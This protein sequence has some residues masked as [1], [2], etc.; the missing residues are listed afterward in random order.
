MSGTVGI[1]VIHGRE[2]VNVIAVD[3]QAL[4]RRGAGPRSGSSPGCP[5]TKDHRRPRCWRPGSSCVAP[6]K[7]GHE[8]FGVGLKGFWA[9]WPRPR[10]RCRPAA[11]IDFGH[12]HRRRLSIPGTPAGAQSPDSLPAIVAVAR[13]HFGGAARLRS[14]GILD[15]KAQARHTRASPDKVVMCV[16]S[17]QRFA[18]RR[19]S[20][21]LQTN[22]NTAS[23]AL[24]TA[25]STTP[26][27][28]RPD[29]RHWGARRPN[30]WSTDPRSPVMD[31]T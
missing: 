13:A 30:R 7:S 31:I 15:R 16:E 28:S 19:C 8:P 29:V 12:S 2:D 3:A 26:R 23:P 18:S 27:G 10:C 4:G 6:A 17:T 1:P 11:G 5:A 24:I 21:S 20:S 9:L 14:R 22:Q 25:D